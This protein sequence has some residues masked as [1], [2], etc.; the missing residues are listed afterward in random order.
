MKLEDKD[1]VKLQVLYRQRL[2]KEISMEEARE[3]GL[4]LLTLVSH[5]HTPIIGKKYGN[6]NERNCGKKM[7]TIKK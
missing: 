6:E 4:Q 7:P 3:I 1:I 2:G 5:I